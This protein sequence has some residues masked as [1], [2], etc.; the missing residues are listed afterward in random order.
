MFLQI[1]LLIAYIKNKEMTINKILGLYDK[2]QA[3]NKNDVIISNGEDKLIYDFKKNDINKNTNANT[4]NNFFTDDIKII[5]S[6]YFSDPVYVSNPPKKLKENTEQNIDETK[7]ENRNRLKSSKTE[8]DPTIKDDDQQVITHISFNDINKIQL[9]NIIKDNDKQNPIPDVNKNIKEINKASDNQI[10]IKKYCD[11]C[12]D[13]LY[14][15]QNTNKF[16]NK[17]NNKITNILEGQDIFS[18]HLIENYSDNEDNRRYPKTKINKEENK[19]NLSNNIIIFSKED[20]PNNL[21][22]EGSSINKVRITKNKNVEDLFK[23]RNTYIKPLEYKE[24]NKLKEDEKNNEERLK[25]DMDID[26]EIKVDNTRK[27]DTRPYPTYENNYSTLLKSINQPLKI[28]DKIELKNKNKNLSDTLDSHR[29]ML[30][31]RED[32]ETCGDMAIRNIE[33]ENMKHKYG[34]DTESLK[35]KK[36]VGSLDTE[37]GE[38]LE[39][40]KYLLFF[41]K[42][43]EKREIWLFSLKDTKDTIPYFVRYSNLVFCISFLF[44]LNCFFFSESNV[45]MRYLNA[46]SGNKNDIIYYFKNELITTIYV[47]LIGIVF[48]MI[49]IKLV[50]MKLF[51]IGK[52]EKILMR[53]SSEKGLNQNELEIL[54]SKRRKFMN[55]YKRKLLVYFVC[56]EILNLLIAYICICYGAIFPNSLETFLYGILFSLIISFIICFI[57]CLFI[58]TFYKCGKCLNCKCITSTYNYLS[59]IF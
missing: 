25:T 28:R 9:N 10:E 44:L 57:I 33:K 40:E 43:F 32:G 52:A 50:V 21:L 39:Q 41:W 1:N 17:K 42:Y 38:I 7:S 27:G 2:T 51:I 45:H 53:S 37:N 49:M 5:Q 30:K 35:D 15:N 14:S 11:T 46:L 36:T 59:I 48:K 55:N 56:L 31:S 24:Y 4:N 26:A 47:S 3:T 34:R 20:K 22:E 12:E 18:N 29:N 23:E 6:E 16:N 58:V 19:V 13:I 54:Q 8:S